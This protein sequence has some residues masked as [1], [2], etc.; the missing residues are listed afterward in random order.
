MDKI[1]YLI[2]IYGIIISYKKQTNLFAVN[3]ICLYACVGVTVIDPLLRNS[4]INNNNNILA[5]A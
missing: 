2:V 1:M 3:A 4:E 5:I